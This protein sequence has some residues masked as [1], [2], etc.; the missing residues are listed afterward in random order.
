[1]EVFES[2]RGVYLRGGREDDEI[3]SG[4][5]TLLLSGAFCSTGG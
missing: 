2:S 3:K 4:E 1:M 5:W